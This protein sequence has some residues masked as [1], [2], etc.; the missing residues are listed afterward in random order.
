MSEQTEP[1]RQA[2]VPSRRRRDHLPGGGYGGRLASVSVGALPADVKLATHAHLA[3]ALGGSEDSFT[4]DLLRLIAKADP[5]NRARL[6][7]GFPK[8]VAAWELWMEAAPEITAGGLASVLLSVP[9]R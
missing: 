7:R 1:H 5:G 8:Q 6:R 2:R 9:D 3:L 4:G